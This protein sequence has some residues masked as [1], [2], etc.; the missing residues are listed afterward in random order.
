MLLVTLATALPLRAQMSSSELAHPDSDLI[1]QQVRIEGNHTTPVAKLPRLATRIGQPFDPR[2]V[3]EDV[4]QLATSRKFLDVKSQFQQVPGG[5]AVI[6]Q[7]VERPTL[8]YVKFVGNQDIATR[9]LKKKSELEVGAPLDP[10][11][12]EE[13]RR[14]IEA[15]YHDKGY[16]HI[17]ITT[18]EG[19]K[20]G[21]KGAVFLV[22]EGTSERVLW[23]SF[24]G[25]TI[26]DDSR[27][28]TQIKTKPGI[29]WLFG[30]KVDRKKIDDDEERLTAYYRGLGFFQAKVGHELSFNEEKNWLSLQ[31]IINE[32]PRYSIRN[33][34]FLGN[35]KFNNDQLSK[36]LELAG[37]KPF[38]QSSLNRDLAGLR[39]IYGGHG[40]VF[41]DIQADPRLL[42]DKPEVDLVY[43]IKEGARYRVGHVNINISGEN[44]H[45]NHATVLNRMS[46]RPG[47][48]VDTRKLR[49]DERRLKFSN[50]FNNDPSKGATP[51]IV[52][53]DPSDKRDTKVASRPKDDPDHPS[54]GYRGQSPDDDEVVVDVVYYQ[55][56]DGNDQ[57]VLCP[58][59]ESPAV[60]A[61]Q[62]PRQTAERT[63][64]VQVR[65]QDPGYGGAS[66]G[67]TG[68]DSNWQRYSTPA[69]TSQGYLPPGAQPL[70]ANTATAGD[71]YN[72]NSP[73]YAPAPAPQYAPAPYAG[74]PS[75][76]SVLGQPAP[77]YRSN[78]QQG[79]PQAGAPQVYGQAPA[80]Q[81]SPPA[82][83]PSYAQPQSGPVFAPAPSSSAPPA[84][85][86]G[87][88]VPATP[89]A[90]PAPLIAPGDVPFQVMG[91]PDPYV[92]LE[93]QMAEAQTG[94]LMLG[95]G[96]N[97]DA[98]LVGNF[99][100][101]EQNF[102]WRRWPRSWEDIRNGTAFR[103]RGERF[104]IEANPGT[105]VQRYAASFQEPYL[106]DTPIALNLSGYFFD[107]IYTD[108]TE[109]RLGGR[110]GLGYAF[111]PDLTGRVAFRGEKV[112]ISNPHTPTPPELAEVVGGNDLFGFSVGG[113]HDTRDSPFLP[114]QGHLL[115]ADFEE[116]T[117]TFV[118][119]RFTMEGRQYF[120]L[121]QRADGSGRHVLGV[122]GEFGFSGVD[123]PIYDNFFAGGFSSIRGFEFRGASPVVQG[124]TVGGRLE[125]IG[126]A[127]YLFPITAD[128]ALRGVIFCDVGTVERDIEINNFRVAP[129]FG[130]RISVPAMG[131]APIALDFAFPVAHA[132][133]DQI[134]NFSFFVGAGRSY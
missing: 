46:L 38:D 49:D 130:L 23:T 132:P 39:D 110:V 4:R 50:L 63:E 68:P 44:P 85:A 87:G 77:G 98:G 10:Y 29:M 64:N 59:Q 11:A 56:A 115:S 20:P 12:V 54:N 112:T 91:G 19:T 8:Q 117:G 128:D 100:I 109:Q 37:G 55:D 13:A 111:T 58:S 65:F 121:R 22:H 7:V 16:N 86:S 82:A 103:G 5:V 129:G 48:I 114:T 102:D 124:V 57:V 21:D 99:V 96:V 70:P 9:T 104:R 133:F 84:Y 36:K 17:Q 62:P 15:V 72:Y 122:G 51:K 61:A 88:A 107:R 125:L 31:F 32:G 6:F 123:T 33:V 106:F 60:A 90:Q 83:A 113:S 52:F 81:Q 94:R 27:L 42:E 3:Q 67:A 18:V 1:I 47:D 43:D 69:A 2:V 26:T 75:S 41:A 127:E 40:Y 71:P 30:G 97:S 24:V 95:V 126:T 131:P 53:N 134:Q 66:V 35:K 120:L 78:F 89:V 14:R 74:A 34:S 92:D 118:Y 45:T 79:A 108:W 101:D 116:V 80:Y 76:G 93:A 28:R 73:R 105:Q 119:P 25:N